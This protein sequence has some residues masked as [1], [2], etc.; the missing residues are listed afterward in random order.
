VPTDNGKIPK[1]S[2]VILKV[3]EKTRDS[4]VYNSALAGLLAHGVENLTRRERCRRE[5][6]LVH[7]MEPMCTLGGRHGIVENGIEIDGL[8][9]NLNLHQGLVG[10]LHLTS[11]HGALLNLYLLSRKGEYW[12]DLVAV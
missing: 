7:M 10:E 8:T 5:V 3:A 12:T 4:P 11:G 6:T 1:V 2:P 9:A